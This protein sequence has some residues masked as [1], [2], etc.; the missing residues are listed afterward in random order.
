MPR[1]RRMV[2]GAG[3]G[4]VKELIMAQDNTVARSLHDQSHIH[5][6]RCRR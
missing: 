6:R 5:I 1:D 3:K 2:T 4:L